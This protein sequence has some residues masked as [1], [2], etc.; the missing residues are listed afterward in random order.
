[1]INI[2]QLSKIKKIYE[3][4]LVKSDYGD[5]S[6]SYH[7]HPVIYINK[8]YTYFKV[9][10]SDDLSCINNNHLKYSNIDELID[11]S[12]DQI[13]YFLFCS[14][15][16][17]CVLGFITEFNK[18]ESNEIMNNCCKDIIIKIKEKAINTIRSDIEIKKQS[19]DKQLNKI[20]KLE[21]EISSLKEEKQ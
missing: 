16:K 9:H 17:S 3:I 18:S 6:I 14:R 1:M 13:N 4:C 12:L 5:I 2:Q 15:K 10:G 8:N 7:I 19:I 21:N 11:N 20:S